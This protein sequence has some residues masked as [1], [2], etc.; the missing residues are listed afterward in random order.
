MA[1]R[2]SQDGIN[3]GRS[4]VKTDTQQLAP[5]TATDASLRDAAQR[6]HC[7]KNKP[8]PQTIL[9]DAQGRAITNKN[10]W[11]GKRVPMPEHA[12]H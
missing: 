5:E 12:K 11:Q 7:L 3:A 4:E 9:V 10:T 1:R 6:A 8:K 2:L